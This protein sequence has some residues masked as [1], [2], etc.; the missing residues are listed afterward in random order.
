MNSYTVV[1]TA[2]FA[3]VVGKRNVA[4]ATEKGGVLT[5][6]GV[7]FAFI[8]IVMESAPGSVFRGALLPVRKAI[9]NPW[10]C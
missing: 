6:G 3:A 5:L 1:N 4:Q 10:V 8:I 7:L 9:A 2:N